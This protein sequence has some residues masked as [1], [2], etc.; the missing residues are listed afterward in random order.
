MPRVSKPEDGHRGATYASLYRARG[1]SGPGEALLATYSGTSMLRACA[2]H[3]RG[4]PTG[5]SD[6]MRMMAIS[7]APATA[8]KHR[9]AAFG[10][11]AMCG[12]EPEFTDIDPA[13]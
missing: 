7:I 4:E 8:R 10:S 13:P 5:P 6:T 9:L 1:E 11:P 12:T 2:C 3:E